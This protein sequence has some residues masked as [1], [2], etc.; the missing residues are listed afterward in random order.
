MPPRLPHCCCRSRSRPRRNFADLPLN[1][2]MSRR[3]R[4]LAARSRRSMNASATVIFTT[5]SHCRFHW[6]SCFLTV[7]RIPSLTCC[8]L[9]P[10]CYLCFLTI[11]CFMLHGEMSKSKRRRS[12]RLYRC[13]LSARVQRHHVPSLATICSCCTSNHE[14]GHAV[15]SRCYHVCKHEVILA[16]AT[17]CRSTYP[18][19]SSKLSRAACKR[20]TTLILT[21]ADKNALP[22][23]AAQ[24]PW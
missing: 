21:E 12:S 15:V 22:R 24:P 7:V 4:L 2:S 14:A 13:R 3:R 10:I 11:S 18:C 6:L 16:A 19:Y 23:R 1:G 17:A 8:L 5:S 20:T 9:S